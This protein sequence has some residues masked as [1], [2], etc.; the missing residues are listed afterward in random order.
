M[1]E[2]LLIVFVLSIVAYAGCGAAA[3]EPLPIPPMPPGGDGCMYIDADKAYEM[4]TDAPSETILIDV[5]TKS[6]HENEHISLE[7]VESLNIPISELELMSKEDVEKKI[8]RSKMIIVY[9]RSGSG[10]RRACEILTQYGYNV[11]NLEGGINAWKSAGYPTT[12]SMPSP[13]MPTET[14]KQMPEETPETP[15]TP[16]TSETPETPETPAPTP[17]PTVSEHPTNT[18]QKSPGAPSVPGFELTFAFVI[19][20]VLLYAF[21]RR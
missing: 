14:P 10:S 6:E 19:F 18:P 2:G 16:E 7:G 15:E 3:E 20:A 9:C 12:A 8:N 13:H 21:R 5:R 1:K 4:L 11:F 17:A